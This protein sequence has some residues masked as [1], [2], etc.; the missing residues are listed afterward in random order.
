[1]APPQE[2]V[3]LVPIMGLMTGSSSGGSASAKGAQI[4]NQSSIAANTW[5]Y[6]FAARENNTNANFPRSGRDVGVPINVYA[7]RP[8]S[9]VIGTILNCINSGNSR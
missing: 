1:M 6:N 5:T 3:C 7:W 4:I 2:V 9:G 8:R